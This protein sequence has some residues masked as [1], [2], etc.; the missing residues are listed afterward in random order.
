MA[1][2]DPQPSSVL[3]V[4]RFSDVDEFKASLRSV[5]VEVLPTRPG[6]ISSMQAVL[7]LPQ[8]EIYLLRTFPRIVD[9]GVS[10]NRLLVVIPYE[11]ID[12]SPTVVNGQTVTETSLILGRGPGWYRMIEN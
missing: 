1:H 12:S 2:F 11:D 8:G 3:S 6:P 7:P 5:A 4:T 10:A 9:V